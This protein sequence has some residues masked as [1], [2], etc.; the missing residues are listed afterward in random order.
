MHAGQWIYSFSSFSFEQF[1]GPQENV[2]LI[3]TFIPLIE[4][5]A[6]YYCTETT[7]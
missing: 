3:D 1:N 7:L 5:G 6:I 4:I 2:P